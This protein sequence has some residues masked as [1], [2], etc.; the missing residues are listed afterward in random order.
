M[1]DCLVERDGPVMVLTFNR[2]ERMNSMGG[3]LLADFLAA[4]DEG[5]RDDRVKAFV[6]TGAGRAWCA[7]ADLQAIGAGGPGEGG[8]SGGVRRR[9]W[10]PGAAE[11]AR[12][13]ARVPQPGRKLCA[14]PVRRAPGR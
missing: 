14:S 9:G 11:R 12:A 5:R 10:E 3:T 7:G 8:R 1:P 6:V 4:I 13:R 2:P